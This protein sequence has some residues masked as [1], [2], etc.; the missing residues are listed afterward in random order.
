[1]GKKI[2]EK[3]RKRKENKLSTV[4]T[5]VITKEWTKI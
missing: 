1:M 5:V 2:I 4:H 3:K